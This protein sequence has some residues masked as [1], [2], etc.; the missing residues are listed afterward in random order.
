MT[1]STVFCNFFIFCVDWAHNFFFCHLKKEITF[2]ESLPNI[3]PSVF[4]DVIKEK[5]CIAS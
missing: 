4:F 3:K 1:E 2:V 5:K